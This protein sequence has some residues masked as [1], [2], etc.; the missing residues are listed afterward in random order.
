MKLEVMGFGTEQT[1][2]S[3]NF[4]VKAIIA[5]VGW[6]K[7][8]TSWWI[9]GCQ[10]C[11]MA[12]A[13]FDLTY[14]SWMSLQLHLLGTGWFTSDDNKLKPAADGYDFLAR[15]DELYRAIVRDGRE[16]RV[17]TDLLSSVPRGAAADIGCG[18][19]HSVLRLSR[20]GFAPLYAYD[21]SPVAIGIAQALLDLE[22]RT[23]HLYA[24]EAT[25][26]GEIE[27]GS[28]AL[29]YSRGALH[30]FR[31]EELAR[32]FKRT[33]RPGGHV[34]AELVALGYYC[35]RKHLKSLLNHRWRQPL[36][37]ARTIV[38]TLINEVLVTQP[39]LAAGAPEIGYTIRS[40]R[41]LA[42]WARLEVL[43]VSPA[44]TSV[45]YLVVMRKPD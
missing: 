32:T 27:S 20:L 3:C 29:I 24:R 8:L 45:G 22:G 40:I 1:E 7:A 37:Y 10:A 31:Q 15:V 44:P 23:A 26:L 16:D 33:L 34:V 38:R 9:S 17:V 2:S 42:R 43:S 28:L 14:D 4:H 19:G 36:S 41:R 12:S 30:Y 11:Q 21:L 13:Q 35:Q 39:R 6:L 18:P 25:S 5:D